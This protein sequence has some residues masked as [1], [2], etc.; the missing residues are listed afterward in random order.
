MRITSINY[1]KKLVDY[2]S[3]KT[4]LKKLLIIKSKYTHSQSFLNWILSNKFCL[5]NS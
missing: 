4:F 5:N 3:I 2:L 1:N